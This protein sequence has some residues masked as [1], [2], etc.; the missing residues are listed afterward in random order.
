M[1]NL[2]L[3]ILD[4]WGWSED[5]RGNAILK[6]RKPNFNKLWN[7]CPHTLLHASG[8]PVGLPQGQIG[9]SEVGHMII[10]AGR[11]VPQLSSVITN[12]IRSGAFFNNKALRGA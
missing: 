2:L 9:S 4:G 5:A 6:A 1:N 3:L 12:S 8:E 7:N 11:N 10:G